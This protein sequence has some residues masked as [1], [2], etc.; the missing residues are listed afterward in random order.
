LIEE[1]V[2]FKEEMVKTWK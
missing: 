2:L 1:L